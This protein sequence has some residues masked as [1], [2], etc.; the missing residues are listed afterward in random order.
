MS[1][2][3]EPSA[4]IAKIE[5]SAKDQDEELDEGQEEWLSEGILTDDDYNPSAEVDQNA[6]NFNSSQ[7]NTM[8]SMEVEGINQTESIEQA[9]NNFENSHETEL[10]GDLSTFLIRKTDTKTTS[11]AADGHDNEI[12]ESR[13]EFDDGN[14]TDEL[15]RML[16]E[17]NQA[18]KKLNK[19]HTR[20]DDRNQGSSDED[21][22]IFDGAKI[23]RLKVARNA[24]MKKLPTKAVPEESD[25]DSDLSSD[26]RLIVK[27][28]FGVTRKSNNVASKS[29]AKSSV[30][31]MRDGRN[32]KDI[33]TKPRM[34]R[35][36]TKPAEKNVPEIIDEEEYL[37]EEQF[38]LDEGLESDAQRIMRPERMDEEVPTDGDSEPDDESLYDELPSS[39]SEDIMDWF[40]LDLRAERAGDYIPLLGPSARRLL[41][42]ERARAAA[43]LSA[44]KQSAAALNESSAGQ[45]A[46]LRRAAKQLQELDAAL[47]A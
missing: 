26:E 7:E 23:S 45:A 30:S 34:Q 44:L 3:E 14:D 25:R 40:T 20:T 1:E 13:P 6:S 38:D 21:E 12:E 19:T 9:L 18:K 36:E 35:E 8:A 39:D 41:S 47:R 42:T 33:G 2:V 27:R 31:A 17:D 29:T 15:L 22:Y 16:G 37:D 11:R 4:K 32:V 10:P 24:I 5:V 28:M 46:A 43:R